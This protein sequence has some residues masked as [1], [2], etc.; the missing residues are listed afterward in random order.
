[1][2][3]TTAVLQRHSRIPVME[4]AQ[5]VVPALRIVWVDS[6]LHNRAMSAFLAAG[7]RR[8]ALSLV[9]CVSLELARQV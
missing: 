2:V 5:K 1:M 3:E 8:H 7:G 4:F 6:A 9:D